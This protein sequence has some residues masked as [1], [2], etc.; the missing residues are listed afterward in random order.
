MWKW[1]YAH[2]KGITIKDH[3][4]NLPTPQE[5]HNH[6]MIEIIYNEGDKSKI[7]TKSYEVKYRYRNLS[8]LVQSD[9]K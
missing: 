5:Y 1:K 3:H 2:K 6:C 7:E 8:A 4:I 9:I